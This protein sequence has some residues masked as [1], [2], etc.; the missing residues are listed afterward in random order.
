MN[1]L[2][3]TALCWP[4]PDPDV[5]DPGT[6]WRQMRGFWYAQRALE[7]L[8]GDQLGIQ[9]TTDKLRE[10]NLMCAKYGVP[11]REI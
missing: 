8:K 1:K 5:R 4:S 6:F 10:M 9:D 3:E 2:Y 11:S 7:R